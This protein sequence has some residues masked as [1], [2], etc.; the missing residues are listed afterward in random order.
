MAV[1]MRDHPG[2]IA[3]PTGAHRVMHAGDTVWHLAWDNPSEHVTI[4]PDQTAGAPAVDEFTAPTSSVAALNAALR[5]LGPVLRA[6]NAS[7][8]DAIGT[9]I[10]R[11]VIRADQ[12]RLMYGRFCRTHGDSVPADHGDLHLFP[13]PKVVVDLPR[14][15]FAELGM[16]FKHPAL[17]AAAAAYL[18]HGARWETLPPAELCVALQAVPRIGPW[19]AGAA[20][21]D[22]SGDFTVYP[23]ADLAVRTWARRAAPDVAWPDHEPAFAAIWKGVAGTALSALT[24]VTLAWG[25]AYVRAP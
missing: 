18:T 16:A 13:A 22:F 1:L 25:D 24:V 15:A 12:A 14:N 21:A 20:V 7:L 11:Q 17:T 19:T 2:W 6:R 8:W 23:Y 5:P 10:I 9:A 3:T 4:T